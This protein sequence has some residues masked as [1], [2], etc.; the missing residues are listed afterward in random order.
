MHLLFILSLEPLSIKR[1]SRVIIITP[2]CIATV[3]PTTG[4]IRDRV[5]TQMSIKTHLLYFSRRQY[6]YALNTAYKLPDSKK[7]LVKK[8]I[9]KKIKSNFGL[10][11]LL[12]RIITHKKNII[13]MIHK[14]QIP[15]IPLWI[16]K[17]PF[18]SKHAGKVMPELLIA[19]ITGYINTSSHRSTLL[20]LQEFEPVLGI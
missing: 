19:F 18:N 17:L 14:N 16:F 6:L 8:Q 12:P 5:V 11:H 1:G 4:L 7:L 9:N 15:I 2:P 13:L 10:L 20:N 3:S